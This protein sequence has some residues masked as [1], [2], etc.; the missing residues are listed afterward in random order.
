MTADWRT[1]NL[2]FSQIGLELFNKVSTWEKDEVRGDGDRYGDTVKQLSQKLLSYLETVLQ[3]QKKEHWLM[4]L[5]DM[6]VCQPVAGAEF[7][8]GEM[9]CNDWKCNVKH[10]ASKTEIGVG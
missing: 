10:C 6:T 4:L 2:R 8:H 7:C 5:T 9:H 1:A 3:H